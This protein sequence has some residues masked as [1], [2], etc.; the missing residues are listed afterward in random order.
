MFAMLTKAEADTKINTS[1]KDSL[2][3]ITRKTSWE[4]YVIEKIADLARV[5]I[6]AGGTCGRNNPFI[7]SELRSK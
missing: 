3:F 5:V 6:A 1:V 7:C 4:G 2:T